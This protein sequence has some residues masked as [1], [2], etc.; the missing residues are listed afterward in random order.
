MKDKSYSFR[1]KVA[2]NHLDILKHVNNVQYLYWVQD[3]AIKHWT[4]LTTP[5]ID[6]KYFWVVARHEI[7]YLS[8]ALLNDKLTIKTW[9][10]KS[11]GKISERFVNIYKEDKLLVKVKTIWCLMDKRT[12]KSTVIPKE[13]FELL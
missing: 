11:K 12:L 3:A 6:K 4:L 10:G 2:E 1:V 8:S 13:V 9:I 7:D 5:E